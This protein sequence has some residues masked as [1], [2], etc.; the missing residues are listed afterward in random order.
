MEVHHHSSPAPGGTHTS[1]KKWT[2]Y[3]WE[4]LMLFLAVFCG[5]LAE[6]QREHMIE[7]QRAK[8]YAQ[9]LYKDLQNDTADIRKAAV[10]ENRI[11]STIDS[12]VSFI[13]SPDL[14][15][16]GGI[17]YYYMRIGCWRY[18][19]DWNKATIDQLISSGN[20]RYFTNTTLVTLI[21]NYN[22]LSNM[23]TRQ[24]D[25]I[26]EKRNR[27]VVYRDRIAIAKYEQAYSS[28]T[29]AD[30]FSGSKIAYIDSLRSINMLIQSNAV[31]LLNAFANALL[32]TKANRYNLGTKYYPKAIELATE[33]MELLKKEYHLN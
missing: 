6:N 32:D 24:D 17:L 10:Y 19:V 21:S 4:F 23:I 8:A 29:M 7:H 11:V 15:Q 9:S 16:K 25:G 28:I 20:L 14:S 22:T 12:L 30:I 1:R 26:S 13:N 18:D 5:F 33:I 3:F 31:D 27:A 2:H